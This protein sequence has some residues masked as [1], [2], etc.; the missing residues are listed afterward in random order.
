MLEF[1][2]I[3]PA[4]VTD[5]GNARLSTGFD[6]H[7][8]D[9]TPVKAFVSVVRVEL[10]VSIPVVS[11]VTT[12]PPLDGTLNCTSASKGEEVLQRLGSIVRA[13]SPETV[14]TRGNTCRVL[15]YFKVKGAKENLPRPVT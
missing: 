14:V 2:D 7:P 15:R 11:S 9:V 3:V 12:R 8:T 10:S 6:Q 4:E 5:I 13:M 1:D